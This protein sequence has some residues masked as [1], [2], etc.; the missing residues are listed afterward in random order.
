MPA[1][2]CGAGTDDEQALTF[3]TRTD[4]EMACRRA[5]ED[6]ARSVEPASSHSGTESCRG[7]QKA[8]S[9]GFEEYLKRWLQLVKTEPNR[10]RKKWTIGTAR[11]QQGK[12]TGY[13]VPES[14]DPSRREID[15]GR[16]FRRAARHGA[17]EP[18]EV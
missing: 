4:A 2:T 5:H 14:G 15:A 12:A 18:S 9:M 1:V 3:L 8:R 10:S 13:L 16:S 7:R 11:S 17:D 6:S